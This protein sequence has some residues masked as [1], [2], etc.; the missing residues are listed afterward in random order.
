MALIDVRDRVDSNWRAF[1]L[2]TLRRAFHAHLKSFLPVAAA[3][4]L[5]ACA[6]KSVP[7]IPQWRLVE[8]W[9]VGGEADGPHS[10]V[11]NLGLAQLPNGG[12]VHFDFKSHKLHF[13]DAQGKPLRSVGRQGGGPGEF[14]MV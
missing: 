2:T 10:F 1:A 13:L 5:A 9:R 6:D 11:F 3:L 12:F 7:Q 8:E 14:M 4:L